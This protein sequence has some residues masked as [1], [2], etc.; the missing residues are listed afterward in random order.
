MRVFCFDFLLPALP[1]PTT[2]CILT[3]RRHDRPAIFITT[4]ENE[5]HLRT[6]LLAC[7]CHVEKECWSGQ[8][9]PCDGKTVAQSKEKNGRGGASHEGPTTVFD[10][11]HPDMYPYMYMYWGP[12]YMYVYPYLFSVNILRENDVRQNASSHSSSSAAAVSYMYYVVGAASAAAARI[13]PLYY[14]YLHKLPR[15]SG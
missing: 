5:W 12:Q 9:Y 1:A 14:Q 3:R 10:Q 4:R 2:F 15:R 13:P 7:T 6:T 11:C 8:D